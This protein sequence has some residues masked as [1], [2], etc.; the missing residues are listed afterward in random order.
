M[1]KLSYSIPEWCS[2]R[3]I[4]RSG[5][6]KIVKDGLGPQTYRVGRRRFIS[7]DADVE[8]QRKLELKSLGEVI[9]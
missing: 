1:E 2:Q 6:Y 8:W 4:S 9:Q 5:F 7:R 3:G